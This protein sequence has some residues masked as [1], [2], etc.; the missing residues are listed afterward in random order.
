MQIEFQASPD[1]T[2]D[3]PRVAAFDELILAVD[4]DSALKLLGKEATW[5][6]RM[7]LGSVKYLHDITITHNDLNYM[8]KV[9]LHVQH[10]I[11]LLN[12][13]F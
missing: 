5:K 7:V 12:G 1:S 2:E 4:A 6:E 11:S 8:N 3:D 10:A 13:A 9:R